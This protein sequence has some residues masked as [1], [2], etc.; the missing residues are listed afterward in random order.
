MSRILII[1]DEQPLRRA[2]TD[3][4]TFEGYE[5]IA[6]ADGAAGFTKATTHKPD[7][8]IL[9][10]MLP[11]MSGYDICR[12]LRANGIS[13]PILMLTA[14]GEEADRIAGL[15]LGFDDYLT[16]PFSI[17]ERGAC[18][19][20]L[21]RRAASLRALPDSLRLI[22]D[23]FAEEVGILAMARNG[24]RF[25]LGAVYASGASTAFP[26]E[27][28]PLPVPGAGSDPPASCRRED[29][30]FTSNFT[31]A[32]RLFRLCT[33]RFQQQL[34]SLCQVRPGLLQ[35]PA[36]SVGAGKFLDE[37]D[38]PLWHLLEYCSQLQLGHTVMLTSL[39]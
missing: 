19:R 8:V 29:Q 32:K 22:A 17:G 21:L 37:T 7:L 15:D 36:P 6:A 39:S 30:R 33:V 16:K 2:L 24:C 5:V 10:L 28:T 14:R 34:Y 11:L 31:L 4:F 26:Q 12:K 1:E 25:S 20:A 3:N 38:V 27:F 23:P 35:R 13:T 18:V 9:D